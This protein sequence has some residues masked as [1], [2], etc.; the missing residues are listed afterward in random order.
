M[1]EPGDYLNEVRQR[2]RNIM[3]FLFV[4]SKKNDTI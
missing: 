2:K 3:Y 1:D 4:E